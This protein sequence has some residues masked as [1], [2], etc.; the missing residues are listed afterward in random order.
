METKLDEL[1]KSILLSHF[2]VILLSETW[3]TVCLIGDFNM[4]YALWCKNS[5]FDFSDNST[6]HCTAK[7]GS[8]KLHRN[9]ISVV[10]DTIDFLN[11]F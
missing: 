7:V 3:L 2:Q 4:P 9:I 11:L 6:P 8:L 1:R 5:D 10:P